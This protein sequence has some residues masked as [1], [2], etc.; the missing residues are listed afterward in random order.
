MIQV[1]HIP[2]RLKFSLI[3]YVLGTGMVW[4]QLQIVVEALASFSSLFLNENRHLIGAV[5]TAGHFLASIALSSLVMSGRLWGIRLILLQA[6][7]WHVSMMAIAY[8]ILSPNLAFSVL[9]A[10]LYS[11]FSIRWLHAEVSEPYFDPRMGW[12]QLVPQ[13]IPGLFFQIKG[14]EGIKGKLS[15]ISPSGFFC[16]SDHPSTARLKET[17]SIQL[18]LQFEHQQVECNGS[19]VRFG[20]VD[21]SGTPIYVQGV[22]FAG[23][24]PDQEKDLGDFIETLRSKGHVST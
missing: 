16:F 21:D 22:R 14:S 18:I 10:A 23:N 2:L 12:Y 24:S 1:K 19:I 11:Y 4:F 6:T 17:G 13:V 7:G 8:L 15:A 5:L 9:F 20:K 3:L